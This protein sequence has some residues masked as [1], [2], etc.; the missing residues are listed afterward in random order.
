MARR[1]LYRTLYAAASY[2]WTNQC[3]P[4]LKLWQVKTDQV[5]PH[6]VPICVLC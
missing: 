2:S 6:F 3:V 1:A 4:Y 5:S